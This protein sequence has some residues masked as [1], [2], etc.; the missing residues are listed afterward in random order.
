MAT[1]MHSF[2]VDR[3][4]Y[5]VLHVFDHDS[6]V[7]ILVFLKETFHSVAYSLREKSLG[8]LDLML[9]HCQFVLDWSISII[10]N[11]HVYFRV[12]L[13]FLL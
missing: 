6:L 5:H 4:I 13:L 12:I 9:A 2:F 7:L 3:E 1:P 11:L 10:Y 8:Q